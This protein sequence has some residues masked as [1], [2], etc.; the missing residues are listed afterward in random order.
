MTKTPIRFARSTLRCR[1]SRS[2]VSHNCRAPRGAFTLI[3]LL[4][5]IAIIAMLISLLLPAVQQARESARKSQ[6]KNNLKQFGLALHN[7]HETY[8]Y[9]AP[10]GLNNAHPN[11]QLPCIGWQV[12][13]LPFMDQAALYTQLNFGDPA[14]STWE[15]GASPATGDLTHQILSDGQPARAHQ[16]PFARCPT[17]TSPE[18]FRGWAQASYG[19]SIGSQ[20]TDSSSTACQPYNVFAELGSSSTDAQ[21]SAIVFGRSNNAALVSGMFSYYGVMLTTQDVLDGTSNTIFVGETLAN[22]S[23]NPAGSDVSTNHHRRGWWHGN[24]NGAAQ[25]STVTPINDFTTCDNSTRITNAACTDPVNYNYSWGFKS[26]HAGGAQFLMVDGGVK[27]ISENID[28]QTY[29][30]LG[31]RA[32]GKTL[33]EF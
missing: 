27:Y 9:F 6:C 1:V 32:D 15:A 24:S 2:R 3:E 10:S 22:C 26:M 17:D 29:Q 14:T 5:V 13:I 8:G 20:R 31:G 28:Q 12:R 7:Y 18:M 33:G 16:V 21:V 25:C 30:R 23:W 19:G 4:V 11:T